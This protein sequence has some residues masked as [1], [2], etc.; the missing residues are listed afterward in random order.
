MPPMPEMILFDYGNTLLAEKPFDG[1]AGTTA[2]LANCVDNPYHI[3]VAEI[4][5]LAR[6]LDND[7]G[8]GTPAYVVE[9]TNHA[10]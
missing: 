7:I 6:E 3:G 4:Q 2:V 8:R 1:A 5:K 9:L 10:F